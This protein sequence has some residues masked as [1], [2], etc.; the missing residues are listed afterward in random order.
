M[1]RRYPARR[2]G[3]DAL[4]LAREKLQ[5]GQ[6]E[7]TSIAALRALS[8]L[9]AKASGDSRPERMVI[10]LSSDAV[11]ESAIELQTEDG[12]ACVCTEWWRQC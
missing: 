5:E 4:A 12:R 7:E 1:P 8:T 2:V 11:R 6:T 3:A 9:T 10:E